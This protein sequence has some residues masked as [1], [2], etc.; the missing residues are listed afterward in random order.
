VETYAHIDESG[1]WLPDRRRV[2]AMAAVLTEESDH[3]LLRKHLRSLLL[4]DRARRNILGR[5]LP[6][7]QHTEHVSQVVVESWAGGDK[8]DR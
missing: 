3:P 7:L 4:P 5:L 8:H 2:Y 1:R 6:R